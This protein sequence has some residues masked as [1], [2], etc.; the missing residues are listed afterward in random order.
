M[1]R[2]AKVIC[3]SMSMG[4]RSENRGSEKVGGARL[5]LIEESVEDVN[6]QEIVWSSFCKAFTYGSS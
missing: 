6:Q 2:A 1:Y 4:S 5:V 3:P